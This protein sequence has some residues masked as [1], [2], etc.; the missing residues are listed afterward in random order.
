MSGKWG[1][2]W[3]IKAGDI[4]QIKEFK[5]QKLDRQIHAY[6]VYPTFCL[7]YPKVQL[8]GDANCPT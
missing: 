7:D 1:I 3:R 8:E 6:P 2:A 5:V 4:I